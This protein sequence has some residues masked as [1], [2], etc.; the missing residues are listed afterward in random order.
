MASVGEEVGG[1]DA[2]AGVVGRAQDHRACAV[3][4]QHGGIASPGRPVE[5]ARVHLGTDQENAAVLA[6][7]D[8]GIRD[9]EPVQE[10][11]ALVADVDGGNVA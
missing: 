8:P 11:A 5:A 6:D 2:P 3:P 9:R 1:E 4:E 7:A 10:A